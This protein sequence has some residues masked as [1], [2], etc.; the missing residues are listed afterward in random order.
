MQ[1]SVSLNA[2]CSRHWVPTERCD[3][4]AQWTA[5]PQKWARSS[6]LV[7]PQPTVKAL[8]KEHIRSRALSA[9]M[10]ELALLPRESAGAS[11]SLSSLAIK[12][13]PRT[14]SVLRCIDRHTVSTHCLWRRTGFV[15]R[16]QIWRLTTSQCTRAESCGLVMAW[17]L[18]RV[19][20]PGTVA[21]V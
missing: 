13:E 1:P 9:E 7:Q 15:S 8:A 3:S 2:A 18:I 14:I 10:K 11:E 16:V 19:I 17:A 5:A 4:A 12:C 6:L 20:G 21:G